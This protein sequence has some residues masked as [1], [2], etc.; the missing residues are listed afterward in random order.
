MIS[1]VDFIVLKIVI[2]VVI[3]TTYYTRSNN[4]EIELSLSLVHIIQHCHNKNNSSTQGSNKN[5]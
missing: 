1:G 2:A 3:N 4:D 5:T